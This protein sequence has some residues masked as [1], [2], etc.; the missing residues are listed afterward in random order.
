MG[1]RIDEKKRQRAN[2]AGG[3]PVDAYQASLALANIMHE[4]R[5]KKSGAL[6]KLTT[7]LN[8]NHIYFLY[9]WLTGQLAKINSAVEIPDLLLVSGNDDCAPNKLRRIREH[10]ISWVEYALAYPRDKDTVY[11]WQPMPDSLNPIFS[12]WLTNHGQALS[13]NRKQKETL[14]WKLKQR[15]LRTPDALRCKLVQRKDTFHRYFA[16][17]ASRD[18]YLSL[19]AHSLLSEQKIH[20]HSAL[21]YQ[22]LSC[23]Q[24]RYEIFAAQNRYLDRLISQINQSTMKPFCDVRLPE[25]DAL[26]PILSSLQTRPPYI[27]KEGSIV[28]FHLEITDGARTY[29]PIE[30]IRIGSTRTI[31]N[32]RLSN[33]FGY[34]RQSL[35]KIPVKSASSRVLS[36]YYNARTYELALLFILLTGTRPT[37]HISIEREMC[38]GLESALIKDK[39][40][41]R[42]ITLPDYLQQAI[43]AYLALQKRV[44][45]TLKPDNMTNM[46]MLWYL[47][48]EHNTARP[49][50]AKSL[51]LFMSAQWQRCFSSESEPT[52]ETVVP[53]QLRHNFAQHALMVNSPHLT[54]QEIDLLMGHSELGEHLGNDYR[55]KPC[56]KKLINHLNQWPIRLQLSPIQC[57]R[58]HMEDVL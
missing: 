24:I 17:M 50:T 39:G 40:R 16:L 44:L 6:T 23:D 36:E 33:F 1:K 20:H 58:V 55:F 49:L 9:L 8:L 10:G 48:D 51:R 41:Y 27:A 2:N 5:P 30:A 34:L 12:Y 47:I 28:S 38:F 25:T 15:K 26:I 29:I 52:T 13:L 11:L 45:A 42:L 43:Q 32:T 14:Y 54:R 4:L 57:K 35:K 22:T 53:Y 31:E 7:E 21:S 46:N 19:P 3:V 37:H 56:R 18:P